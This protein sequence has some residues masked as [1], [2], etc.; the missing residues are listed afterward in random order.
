[1]NRDIAFGEGDFD[2]NCLSDPPEVCFLPH[3][4]YQHLS[5]RI[6]SGRCLQGFVR[7]EDVPASSSP[8]YIRRDLVG[9]V[10]R[11][12]RGHALS[13]AEF[14]RNGAMTDGDVTRAALS[15]LVMAEAQRSASGHEVLLAQRPDG[16]EPDVPGA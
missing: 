10:E 4:T 2:S 14:A 5:E 9:A 3:R 13:A 1:M 7:V 8:L 11:C 6:A 12:V 15:L 16:G